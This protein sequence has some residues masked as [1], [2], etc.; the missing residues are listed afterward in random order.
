MLGA[1]QPCNPRRSIS[2]IRME[3]T[4]VLRASIGSLRT[5]SAA[6]CFDEDAARGASI[7][8]PHAVYPAG[9]L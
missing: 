2:P 1:L 9:L 6:T 8:A 5:P 7:D 4:P 3:V